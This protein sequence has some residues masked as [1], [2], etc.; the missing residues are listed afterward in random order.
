MLLLPAIA[1]YLHPCTQ[2]KKEVKTSFH[3]TYKIR[4]CSLDQTENEEPQPQVVVAFGF[5][6][7]N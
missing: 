3:V 2:Q 5:R 4:L 6:I 1:S 7:T